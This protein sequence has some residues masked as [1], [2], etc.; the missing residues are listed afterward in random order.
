MKSAGKYMVGLAGVLGV[1]ALVWGTGEERETGRIVFDS[2]RS[3]SFGIFT[4]AEDGSDV[5]M[6]VDSPQQEMYPDVSPDGQWVVYARTGG[7]EHFEN[8]TIR[9][10]RL[11]GSE[12]RLVDASGSFP[13]FHDASGEVY[14]MRERHEIM[15]VDVEAGGPARRLFP[16]APRV[17]ERQVVLPALSPDGSKL[18]FTTDRPGPWHV[19]VVDLSSGEERLVGRGCEPFWALNGQAVLWVSSQHT[20]ERTGIRAL[21]LDEGRVLTVQDDDAPWGHEYFP[22]VDRDASRLLWSACPPGQHAHEWSNYQVFLRRGLEA[23]PERV[24]H[25]KFTNRWPKWYSIEK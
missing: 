9:M 13:R 5:R 6:V 22:W 20:H 8:S 4:M 16:D 12:D 25:D 1:V 19:V 3:G 2:N 17:G 10:C 23:L 14:F 15:M 18:A 24:T 21:M 11:D 7:T